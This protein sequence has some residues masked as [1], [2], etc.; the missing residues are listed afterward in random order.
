MEDFD[1]TER[2]ITAAEFAS[3]LG[4]TEDDVLQWMLA[5][6]IPYVDGSEGEPRARIR[7][8]HS[9][10]GPLTSGFITYSMSHDLDFQSKVPAAGASLNWRR[11]TGATLISKHWLMPLRRGCR[12]WS[13][14]R[15][16]SPSKRR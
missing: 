4:V 3:I 14:Q 12:R 15:A 10:D 5:G 16:M 9:V 2:M 7:E 8:Q 13:P 1:L 6:W 11:W